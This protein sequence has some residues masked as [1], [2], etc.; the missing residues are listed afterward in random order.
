MIDVIKSTTA[1]RQ[2]GGIGGIPGETKENLGT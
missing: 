2:P 1:S